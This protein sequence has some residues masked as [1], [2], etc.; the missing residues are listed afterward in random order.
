MRC[1]NCGCYRSCHC[2]WEEMLE[3]AEK[4]EVMS[5]LSKLRR[6]VAELK[7]ENAS[8]HSLVSAQSAL[9]EWY[10]DDHERS[11]CE[12]SDVPLDLATLE[13]QV[14]ELKGKAKR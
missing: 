1:P 6:M 13:R 9:I 7:A 14:A 3:A 5:D 10:E 4:G 8:L 2:T 12:D 11:D